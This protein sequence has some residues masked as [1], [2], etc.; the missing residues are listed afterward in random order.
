MVSWPCQ[1]EG[2]TVWYRPG[3][4][5]PEDH[6]R[7]DW[8][9]RRGIAVDVDLV[10]PPIPVTETVP[11]PKHAAPVETPPE[12]AVKKPAKAAP[13]ASWQAYAVG[14]GIDPKGMTKQELIAAVR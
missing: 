11:D 3:D 14:C 4:Q 6:P 9:L 10:V 5:I 13:L 12:S 1:I 2:R 7:R 8:L